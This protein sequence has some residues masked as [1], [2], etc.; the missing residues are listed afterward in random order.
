MFGMTFAGGPLL[1]AGNGIK[2]LIV[3]VQLN[4]V[5]LADCGDQQVAERNCHAFR[6]QFNAQSSGGNVGL[7]LQL[8]AG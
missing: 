7:L 5:L 6:P 8:K 2:M 1:D 3:G 4:V